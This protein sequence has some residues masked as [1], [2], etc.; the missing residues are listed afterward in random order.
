MAATRAAAATDDSTAARSAAER[1]LL[2]VNVLIALLDDAHVFSQR[3]NAWLDVAPRRIATC[4]IVENSAV[5]VMSATAY[6]ATHR[7]TP[8][9]VAEGLRAL[10]EGVDHAF[11][12]DDVSLLDEACFHFTRLHGYRQITN[13][14]LL[15]LAVR[16]RGALASF[17]PAVPLSAVRGAAKRHLLPL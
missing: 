8:T 10:T 14:Y 4:P 12:P 17:D 11:W 15:A 3:A 6:C 9:Q 1:V 5:R 13:A 2:D 7:A 16:H